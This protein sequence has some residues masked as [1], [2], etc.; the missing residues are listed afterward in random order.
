M[1]TDPRTDDA[2]PDELIR[3]LDPIMS[4]LGVLFLL[5]VLGQNLSRNSA[6]QTVLAVAGWALWAA[7]AAEFS[8]RLYA[9]PDRLGFLRRRWWQL[10]FLLVPFL[11]FV[12]LVNLVRLVRAGPVVSSAVRGGRSAGAL[13]SS[14]LGWLGAVSAVVVLAASQLLYVLGDYGAYGPALHDAALAT[15]TGEPLSSD[16]ATS[17]VLDVVLAV[18]SLV[19]FA[20]L[21]A[22]LGAYFLRPEQARS[23]ARPNG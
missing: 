3:R 18:Y 23:T 4:V 22:S 2:W 14:R 17:Q 8:V 21:A 6:L 10:V 19:V 16:T 12:R 15:I 1:T 11:R 5:V 13:L 7:F 20:T 9:A